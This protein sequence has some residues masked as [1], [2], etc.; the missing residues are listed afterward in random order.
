[1][2]FTKTI[3]CLFFLLLF[4]TGMVAGYAQETQSSDPN[5][6]KEPQTRTGRREAK[7]QWRE[8]RKKN[9]ELEKARR[10][11]RKSNDKRSRKQM[12]Q[13]ARKAKRVNDHKREFFLKRWFK[14]DGIN[15]SSSKKR[16]NS[17]V[18]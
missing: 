12:R 15:K 13:T 17:K 5:Q 2:T 4:F 18:K 10:K 8:E 6:Q 3:R 11:I 9:F 16:R 7:R 14:R 1:M